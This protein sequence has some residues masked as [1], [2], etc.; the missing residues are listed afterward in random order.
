MTINLI[1]RSMSVNAKSQNMQKISTRSLYSTHTVPVA[2]LSQTL[3]G[4][5]G[6]L[7]STLV[8]RE[9]MVEYAGS[10]IGIVD[11]EIV[12]VIS[13]VSKCRSVNGVVRLFRHCIISAYQKGTGETETDVHQILHPSSTCSPS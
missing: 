13:V 5:P 9:G 11:N 12:R 1:K 4:D 6:N 7:C 10:Y 8:S 3:A 2:R